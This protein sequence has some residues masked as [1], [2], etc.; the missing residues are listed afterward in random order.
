MDPVEIIA[1]RGSSFL[2]PENTR[3]A[4]ELAWQEGADAIEGD[5]RLTRDG[6][7]VCIHDASLKR[8]TGVDRRVEKCDLAEL[9][10]FDAGSWKG[11]QFAGERIPTL[12]EILATVPD[13]KRIYVEVKCGPEI[14]EP[15]YDVVNSCNLSP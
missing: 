6:Q 5:F 15:L 8:T 9:Q 4:M 2:A 10:S 13:G 14:V 1:H 11:P 3:G 12:T 7:I